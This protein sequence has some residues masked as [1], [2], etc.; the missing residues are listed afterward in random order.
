[1]A[2]KNIPEDLDLRFTEKPA[3]DV[4]PQRQHGDVGWSSLCGRVGD[5]MTY[6]KQQAGL[7]LMWDRMWNWVWKD[8]IQALFGLLGIFSFRSK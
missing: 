2:D 5:N 6:H 8:L 4:A 1:M 3:E 7:G